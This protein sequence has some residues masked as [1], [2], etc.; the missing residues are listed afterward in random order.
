MESSAKK[1]KA[2]KYTLKGIKEE[3]DE[4]PNAHA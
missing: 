2:I 4:N 3:A 1:L